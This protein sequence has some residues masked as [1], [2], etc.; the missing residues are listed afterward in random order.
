MLMHERL[1]LILETMELSHPFSMIEQPS[2]RAFLAKTFKG[3]EAT[4]ALYYDVFLDKF[5]GKPGTTVLTHEE[6]KALDSLLK[7]KVKNAPSN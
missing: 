4:S 1:H 2:L 5:P 6:A 3:A 7:Q